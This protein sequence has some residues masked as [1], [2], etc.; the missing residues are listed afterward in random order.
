MEISVICIAVLGAA[1]IAACFYSRHEINKRKKA[2]ILE[3]RVRNKQ[4]TPRVVDVSNVNPRHSLN[5][6]ES[7][8]A[9]IIDPNKEAL[10]R[11]DQ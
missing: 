11:E 1:A 6:D 9:S 7:P 3:I 8:N 4:E 5:Y 2:E 10:L